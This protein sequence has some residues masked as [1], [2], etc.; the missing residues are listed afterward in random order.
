MEEAGNSFL[1]MVSTGTGLGG[2]KNSADKMKDAKNGS[3]LLTENIVK[4][5]V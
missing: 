2:I 5:L 1:K 4:G 3:S